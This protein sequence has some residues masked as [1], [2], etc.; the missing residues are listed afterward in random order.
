MFERTSGSFGK[1]K[2]F[3]RG[4]DGR[5]IF[6]SSGHQVL[7]YLLQTAEGVTCKAAIVYLKRKLQKRGIQFYFAI[8]YHDE[9]AV[10]VKDEYA[11]E[12]KELAIEAFIEAPKWFG[13]NCMGGNAHIG[14]TYAE[15]H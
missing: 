4:L 3:I 1:E 2:A 8:H 13:I 11:E 5:L 9:L 7:N 15:V 6:V 12:V 14:K 10:V